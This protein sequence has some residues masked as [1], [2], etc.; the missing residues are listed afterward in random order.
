[1]VNELRDAPPEPAPKGIEIAQR[2]VV[3]ADGEVGAGLACRQRGPSAAFFA[4]PEFESP[5]QHRP[6]HRV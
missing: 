5:G 4:R 1:V 6:A 2:V 3:G